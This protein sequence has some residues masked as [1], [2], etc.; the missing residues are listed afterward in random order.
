MAAYSGYHQ[1][2][3]AVGANAGCSDTRSG[4]CSGV[5]SSAALVLDYKY[6]KRFDGYIGTFW[7]KVSDGLANGFALNTSTLTTTAGVRFR[8]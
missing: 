6:S 2:S 4:Q 5:E 7:T 8:F 3:Y 1:N